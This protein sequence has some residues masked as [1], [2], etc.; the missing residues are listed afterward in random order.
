M[1]V[2]ISYLLVFFFFKQK[3]AYDIMPSLVGS[4]MCI[5]DRLQRRR[6][7]WSSPHPGSANWAVSQA[8]L[9]PLGVVVPQ[10]ATSGSTSLAGPTP[11][12][13]VLLLLIGV[14][15][16]ELA[17]WGRRQHVAAGRRA[18]Y[19]GGIYATAEA[20]AAGG[21]PSAVITEL[22]D[23]LFRL[24]SLRSCQFQH[25][26]AGLGNPPRLQRNGHV[27]AGH[28]AWDGEAEGLPRDRETKLLVESDGIL[29]GRF[30]LTPDTRPPWSSGSSPSRW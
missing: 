23:R 24:L 3:T 13:P 22:S 10:L 29:Q 7:P 19:L 9:P 2:I 18:G 11:S 27:V 12:R 28:R 15:V 6:H 14:A 17:V 5:R 26:V 16:T 25:G 20:V 8:S 4:E 21:S 1:I 30:L